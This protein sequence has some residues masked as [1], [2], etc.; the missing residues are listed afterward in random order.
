MSRKVGQI[1]TGMNVYEMADALT[2]QPHSHPDVWRK[3]TARLRA[4]GR[5]DEAMIVE[6]EHADRFTKAHARNVD[7]IGAAV[8]AMFNILDKEEQ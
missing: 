4:E 3:R 6:M 8:E 1:R 5:A 2:L 7:R